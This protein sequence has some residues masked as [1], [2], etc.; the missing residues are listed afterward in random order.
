MKHMVVSMFCV[1]WLFLGYFAEQNQHSLGDYAALCLRNARG[2][3]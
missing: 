3:R 2:E 1:T